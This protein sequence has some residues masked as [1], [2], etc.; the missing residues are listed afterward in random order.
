MDSGVPVS[1]TW[2]RGGEFC[3]AAEEEEIMAA[4]GGEGAGLGGGGGLQEHSCHGGNQVHWCFPV[5]TPCQGG[6]S[7]Q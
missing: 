5:Q 7:G 2:L 3:L 6:P 4:E 1:L